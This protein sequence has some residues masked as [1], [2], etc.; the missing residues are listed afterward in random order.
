MAAT[1]HIEANQA[2]SLATLSEPVSI[3]AGRLL[4]STGNCIRIETSAPLALAGLVKLE[5][6]DTL[7]MGRIVDAF[8]GALTIEI[9][10]LIEQVGVI[11][12]RNRIWSHTETGRQTEQRLDRKH[13]GSPE[14]GANENRP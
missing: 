12:R 1:L 2:V 13:T 9:E 11:Q 3:A 6:N 8:Q 10:H 14:Q 7:A 5:W 4:D